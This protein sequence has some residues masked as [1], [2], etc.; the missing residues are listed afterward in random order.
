MLGAA[1][2]DA[3]GSEA[4]GDFGVARNVRVGANSPK[5]C[6]TMFSVTN[7]GVCTLPL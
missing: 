5:R 1:Q 4:P 7:T 2:A 6:P 3:L